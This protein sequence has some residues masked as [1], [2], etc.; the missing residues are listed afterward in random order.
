MSAYATLAL[1]RPGVVAFVGRGAVGTLDAIGYLLARDA[2]QTRA[3]HAELD[4]AI[5]ALDMA[6]PEEV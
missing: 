2:L 1:A 3:L 6:D 5:E 4:E